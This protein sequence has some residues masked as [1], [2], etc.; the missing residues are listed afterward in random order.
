M[1]EKKLMLPRVPDIQLK[2]WEGPLKL[3]ENFDS[4]SK[5]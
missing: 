1:T 5:N 3:L 4:Q 2:S